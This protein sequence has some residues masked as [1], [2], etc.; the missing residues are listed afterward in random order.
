MNIKKETALKFLSNLKFC[1]KYLAIEY[2]EQLKDAEVYNCVLSR[3]DISPDEALL[4]SK[5]WAN[6]QINKSLL[7]RE[8]IVQYLQGLDPYHALLKARKIGRPEIWDLILENEKVLAF[9]H[10]YD[11]T[12]AI[13]LSREIDF[14]EVY[15]IILG[16]PDVIKSL[17]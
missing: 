10:E 7:G 1:S 11:V 8:D 15:E 3:S 2:S 14:P 5:K 17:E 9:L 4:L 16:R 12:R 13:S 6:P